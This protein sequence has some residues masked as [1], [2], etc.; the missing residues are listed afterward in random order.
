MRTDRTNGTVYVEPQ[1]L[2][3]KCLKCLAYQ[4]FPN[5]GNKSLLWDET[6]KHIQE[7]CI[8]S[9]WRIN[10]KEKSTLTAEW[11]EGLRYG[12]T[13]RYT[14]NTREDETYLF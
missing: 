2:D 13:E 9:V 12:E 6:S 8:C 4:W 14:V 3:I 10:P 7:L 1:G 5:N 11:Q